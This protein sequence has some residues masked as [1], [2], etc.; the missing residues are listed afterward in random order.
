[1]SL[2]ER[3]AYRPNEAARVIGVS[4]D[5]I[6]RLLSTGELRSLKVGAARLITR[7]ALEEFLQ[8][9]ATG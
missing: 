7:E 3:L 4:R 5:V 8:R 6:F 2:E 1:M 9:A